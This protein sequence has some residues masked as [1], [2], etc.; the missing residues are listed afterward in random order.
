MTVDFCVAALEE[1][2]RHYG[3]PEIFNTDQ[4]AQFTSPAFKGRLLKFL[5]GTKVAEAV[6]TFGH[7]EPEF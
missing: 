1:A 4:G 6:V 2:L 3:T 5:N 7:L